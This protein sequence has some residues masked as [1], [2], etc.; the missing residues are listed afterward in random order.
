[1][2]NISKANKILQLGEDDWSD[3]EEEY[4]EIVKEILEK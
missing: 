3:M 4:L 2:N 1:M